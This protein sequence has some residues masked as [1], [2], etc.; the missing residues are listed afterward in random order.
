MVVVIGN[1]KRGLR[2]PRKHGTEHNCCVPRCRTW[3]C[4]RQPLPPIP[5]YTSSQHVHLVSHCHHHHTS[6]HHATTHHSTDQP[7]NHSNTP[8]VSKEVAKLREYESTLLKHYQSYLKQ[9][10]R[11]SQPS[12]PLPHVRVAIKCMCALLT[13]H[14]HFNYT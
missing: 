5:S 6:S 1:I 2:G 14:P 8:Q 11:A 13:T 3:R 9:L 10:L 7:S 12:N 4:T